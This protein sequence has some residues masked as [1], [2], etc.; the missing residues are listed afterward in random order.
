MLFREETPLPNTPLPQLI[1]W[2]LLRGIAVIELYRTERFIEPPSIRKMPLSLA[3]QQ[4]L[5]ILASSGELSPA[6]LAERVLSLPPFTSLDKADYRDLLVSMVQ[7]EYIELTDEGGCIVG[8]DGERLTNNFKFYA[9]FAD[10][11]DF[12]VRAGSDEIGT[13]TTP[14]PVGDRFALAGRVWQVEEVDLAHRL[15]FVKAVEG[16]MEIS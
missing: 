1:P 13:I 16:K 2:G 12:T 11:E 8:L 4:T 6:M 7:N 5:S 3:F 10:S 14:P 9:V 15:I